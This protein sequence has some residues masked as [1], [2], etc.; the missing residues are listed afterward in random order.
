MAYRVSAFEQVTHE[1]KSLRFTA[2]ERVERL[3]KA[4]VT[5]P[6]FDDHGERL[7]HRVSLLHAQ[8]AKPLHGFLHGHAEH[9]VDVLVGERELERMQLVALPFALGAGHI[10]VAEELHLDLLEAIAPAALAAAFT[11]V[12]AEE[13]G[14]YAL[15]LRIIR[16]R[17]ERTNVIERTHKHRRRAARCAREW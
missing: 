11:A 15:R 16:L 2:R 5:E 6:G 12:E 3:T 4:Q 9:L 13:A 14:R 10:Q 1:F 8:L 7:H 17:K